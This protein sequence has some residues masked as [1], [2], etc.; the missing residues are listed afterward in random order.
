VPLEQ[1]PVL[2]LNPSKSVTSTNAKEE[3]L[4]A[5]GK[6][7]IMVK[8]EENKLTITHQVNKGRKM[9]TKLAKTNVADALVLDTGHQIARANTNTNS[10]LDAVNPS[11]IK[12]TQK[13]VG[14]H[15]QD[16]KQS[17]PPAVH[18]IEEHEDSDT[19]TKNE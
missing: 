9:S 6:V 14:N 16:N 19:N 17:K 11:S 2:L 3:T 12:E 8:D 13:N 15:Q 5:V 18:H 7:A 10:I 1:P 4:E